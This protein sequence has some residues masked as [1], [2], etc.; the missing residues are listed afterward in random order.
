MIT[1]G[2]GPHCRGTDQLLSRVTFQLFD[3]PRRRSPARVRVPGRGRRWAAFVI[4][5]A[6]ATCCGSTSALCD[7]ESHPHPGSAQPSYSEVGS[8]TGTPGSRS[9]GGADR[10]A[11][12]GNPPASEAGTRAI[13]RFKRLACLSPR[14]ILPSGPQRSLGGFPFHTTS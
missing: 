6:P 12:D 3:P 1:E 4:G 10:S 9:R 13:G 11:G 7:I 14:R 5:A 2:Q 8:C